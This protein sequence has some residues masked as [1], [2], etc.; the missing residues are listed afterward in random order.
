MLN[1][2]PVVFSEELSPLTFDACSME[3]IDDIEYEFV[4]GGTA[5]NNL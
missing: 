2:M 5:V 4:G 3:F 1:A